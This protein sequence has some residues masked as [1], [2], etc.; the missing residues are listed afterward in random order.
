VIVFVYMDLNVCL[1]DLYMVVYVFV[2][3]SA[4]LWLSLVYFRHGLY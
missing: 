1:Y 4:W 3:Y 2:Y